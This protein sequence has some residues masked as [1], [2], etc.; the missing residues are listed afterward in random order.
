MSPDRYDRWQLPVLDRIGAQLRE[1]ERAEA[2]RRRRRRVSISGGLV[3]ALVAVFA[4]LD[5][6]QLARALSPVNRAPAAAAASESVRFHSTVTITVHGDQQQA[7]FTE[8]GEIDFARRNYRTTLQLGPGGGAIEQRRVDGVLYV[9]QLPGRHSQHAPIRWLGFPL[10]HEAST[11]FASAPESEE[12]TSPLVLLDELGGTRAPVKVVD[13][14]DLDGVPTTRYRLETNLASLLSA[15]PGAAGPPL[16]YRGIG[17]TLTVWLD[18][19]GRPRR[20]DETVTGTSTGG[21]VRITTVTDFT[22]YGQPVAVRAPTKL[23]VTAERSILA[24]SPLA[25]S[26]SRFFEHLL[27]ADP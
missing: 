19:H 10:A 15:S 22:G 1:L 23:S 25:A 7:R 9:A 13:T 26:P 6:G 4:F 20:V 14:E 27:Y 24:P 18:R 8:D 21:E 16:S 3:A 12:F 2:I 17:A 11:T 5:M